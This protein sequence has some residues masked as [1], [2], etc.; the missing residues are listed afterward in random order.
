MNVKLSGALLATV[1]VAAAVGL[2]P[3]A[4]P[5]FHNV[6]CEGSY[7]RHLQGVCTNGVD[8]IYWSFT[9][10]L[11]KT[12]LRGTPLRTIDVRAHHGDLCHHD[13]KLYI[14]VN[15]GR[16]NDPEKRA[17]SWVYVYDAG[18]LALLA[19]HKTPELVYGA[20]GIAYHKGRFLVVGGLPKGFE[21]NYVY[22]YDQAFRF[23][24]KHVLHSGYTRMGI[25]TAAYARGS[26]WFGCY[27]TP[28][29]LLKTEEDF[30]GVKRFEFDCA[31]G[32]VPVGDD[33]FLVARGRCSKQEGCRGEL[34]LAR[35]D[36][37]QGLVL[38]P[39]S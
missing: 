16:F 14:A 35:P 31:L 38:L 36:K 2:A 5:R 39:S 19:K 4:P 26:W 17:D 9:D 18:N 28:R 1:A 25:Q 6:K 21:E 27:G 29:I 7:H 11:V 33:T 13:G 20:G 15:F 32:I 24:R 37:D 12:D 34:L 3:G 8:A 30:R 23:I 22:E 10:V